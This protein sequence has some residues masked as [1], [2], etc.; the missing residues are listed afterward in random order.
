MASPNR[1]MVGD[2]TQVTFDGPGM[3]INPFQDQGRGDTQ[4]WEW[5]VDCWQLAAN[6]TALQ[7]NYVFLPSAIP[8]IEQ[9]QTVA[10]ARGIGYLVWQSEPQKS[11]VAGWL[12]FKRIYA[13]VPVT[14]YVG[15]SFI[16][17][18]QFI[19]TSGEY[20]WT[21][22]PTVEITEIPVPIPGFYKYEYFVGAY[23]TPLFTARA[24]TL[25]GI[26]VYVGGNSIDFTQP[27]VAENSEFGIY[28]MG[29]TYRKT[30]YGIWPSTST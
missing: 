13:G 25:W 8:G 24:V 1:V 9:M 29:I 23:P 4:S 20:D 19:S 17:S 10:T 18:R 27:F 30:L 15:T 21:A 12:K 22:P 11:N 16:Y 5:H 26:V 14:Q 2:L 3:F 7:N 28:K 6:F